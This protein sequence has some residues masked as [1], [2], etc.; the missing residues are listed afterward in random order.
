MTSIWDDPELKTND[1]Y[2]KFES[3]GDTVTGLILVLRKY[4]FDDGQTVPQLI[5]RKDNGDEVTLNAGQMMLQRR[6]AELRPE[7]GDRIGI[8]Y[9]SMERRAGG[10]TLK[11]FDV[12]VKRK[13]TFETEVPAQPTAEAV[14]PA[15]AAPAA[16][17]ASSLV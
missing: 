11:H 12:A 5:I 8:Q 6:L 13:G 15:P 10:R 17:P 4:T 9:T 7:E 2:V 3:E 14:A 1:N 16:V